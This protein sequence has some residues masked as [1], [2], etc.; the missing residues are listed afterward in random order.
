MHFVLKLLE[1][2]WVCFPLKLGNLSP[3]KA[4]VVIITSETMLLRGFICVVLT[5]QELQDHLQTLCWSVL[6]H[7]CG[8]D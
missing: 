6:L 5:V 7:L 2:Y 8:R 1:I 3:S 4:A